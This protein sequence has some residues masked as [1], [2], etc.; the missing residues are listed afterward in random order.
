MSM[1]APRRTS[2]TLSASVIALPLSAGLA[3]LTLAP[4]RIEQRMPGLVDRVL[5]W[6]AHLIGRPWAAMTIAD[7]LANIAVFVPVGILAYLII[8]RRAWVAALLV[9]PVLSA[10]IELT[11]ALVLPER[12]ASLSDVVAATIG[13]VFGIVAAALCT[14]IS[15]IRTSRIRSIDR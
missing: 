1:L 5:T 14:A 6:V 2:T 10:G 13:S 3:W 12:V 11:Q 8:P 7:F 15:G 9:G 4:L